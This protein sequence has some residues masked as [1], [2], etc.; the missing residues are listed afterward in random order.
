MLFNRE[1][2]IYL[3][4][5]KTFLFSLNSL[6]FFFSEVNHFNDTIGMYDGNG[7]VESSVDCA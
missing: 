6:P 7:R 5:Q 1:V 2:P 4:S 3:F